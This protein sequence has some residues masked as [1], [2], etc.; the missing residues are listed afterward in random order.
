LAGTSQASADSLTLEDSAKAIDPWIG[1]V[2][3]C[4]EWRHQGLQ[5]AYR[6]VVGWIYGHSEIYIQWVTDPDSWPK[7]GKKHDYRPRVIASASLEEFD[8]YESATD[9]NNVRC[10][11]HAGRWTVEADAENG[12]ADPGDPQ[13]KYHISIELKDEPGKYVLHGLPHLHGN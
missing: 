13:A 5:G 1:T 6:I 7:D 2:I 8:L 11:E 10:V 9:L 4:G 3:S 12:D